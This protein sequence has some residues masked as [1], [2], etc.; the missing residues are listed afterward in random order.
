MTEYLIA[1]AT[2]IGIQVLL[3]LGLTVHYGITG[4]VNFVCAFTRGSYAS[5]LLTLAGMRS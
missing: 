3:T 5:A 1:L 4:L 2:I